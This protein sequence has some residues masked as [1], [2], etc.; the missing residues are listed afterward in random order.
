MSHFLV[1]RLQVSSSNLAEIQSEFLGI[2]ACTPIAK[3]TKIARYVQ[4]ILLC[5]K[6]SKI[7]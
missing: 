3:K 2:I 1:F 4:K 5:F 6:H 7:F